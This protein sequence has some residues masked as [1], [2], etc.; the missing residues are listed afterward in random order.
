MRSWPSACEMSSG[1]VQRC[2]RLTGRSP[3]HVNV[4]TEKPRITYS[5]PCQ[6]ARCPADRRDCR[7][8]GTVDGSRLLWLVR[9][10]RHRGAIERWQHC[11]FAAGVLGERLERASRDECG[12]RFRR[13]SATS[14]MGKLDGVPKTCPSADEVMSNLQLSKLV[15][16]G[17]DPSMCQYLFNGSKT[18][19]YAV[20]TFNSSPGMTPASFKASLKSAQSGVEAV[21]G[22][23]DAAFT[24]DPRGL[25]ASVPDDPPLRA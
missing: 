13:T 3:K 10:R 2:A 4:A 12:K 1:S 24:F 25:T 15:L 19:P 9:W 14:H 23:A 16:E 7:I 8:L 5:H 22:L 21:P 18:T 11:G 6:D 17:G 20:I